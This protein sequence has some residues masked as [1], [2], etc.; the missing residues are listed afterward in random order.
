[1]IY[2]ADTIMHPR[3]VKMQIPNHREYCQSE[4]TTSGDR[5]ARRLKAICPGGWPRIAHYQG[6]GQPEMA[7]VIAV[8]LSGCGIDPTPLRGVIA[9]FLEGTP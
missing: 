3:R 4:T 8:I 6:T 2:S 5:A 1:V 9:R 7:A